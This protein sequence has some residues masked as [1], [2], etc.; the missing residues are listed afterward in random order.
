VGREGRH[1]SDLIA[2]H[3]TKSTRVQ[4]DRPKRTTSSFAL[5]VDG[6]AAFADA[7]ALFG[8]LPAASCF[9]DFSSVFVDLSPMS[10]TI[11]SCVDRHGRPL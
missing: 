3:V 8:F 5:P 11:G 7:A 6:A 1:K 4:V 9:F 10:I 2:E